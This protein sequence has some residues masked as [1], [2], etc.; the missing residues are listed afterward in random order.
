ML[1]SEVKE[2]SIKTIYLFRQTLFLSVLLCLQYIICTFLATYKK[3]NTTI[4]PITFQRV[5]GE[6]P[7]SILISEYFVF[8]VYNSGHTFYSLLRFVP[9]WR[10]IIKLCLTDGFRVKIKF[11]KQFWLK[12]YSFHV[13]SFCYHMVSYGEYWYIVLQFHSTWMSSFLCNYDLS[14][15]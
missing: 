1:I 11:H 15:K 3:V 5:S 4:F 9:S 8:F 12:S 2:E 14:T 7:K 13:L 10:V 6:W